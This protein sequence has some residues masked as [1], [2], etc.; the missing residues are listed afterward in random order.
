MGC[1]L[2]KKI[3]HHCPYWELRSEKLLHS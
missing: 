2:L 1:P 3:L